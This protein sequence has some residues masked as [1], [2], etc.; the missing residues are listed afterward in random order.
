MERLNKRAVAISQTNPF[1]VCP[2]D[3]GTVSDQV[4]IILSNCLVL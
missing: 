4:L 3:A 2:G 1:T